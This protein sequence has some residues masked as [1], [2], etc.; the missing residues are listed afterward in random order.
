MHK[1][2][3][4]S[5]I[6]GASMLVSTAPALA[7]D[8]PAPAKEAEPPAA[9]APADAKD[10]FETM[11]GAIQNDKYGVFGSLASPTF[12][13]ALTP[14][15]FKSL[16]EQLAA[17]LQGGHEYRYLGA[18]N[19]AGF[20]VSLWRVRFK[21]GGDDFLCEISENAAGVSGFYLR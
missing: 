10:T 13:A 19:K 1:L 4:L 5:L 20:V 21:D 12:K 3:N 6:L 16:V 17:R 14:A 9:L 15:A 8:A 11:M 7:Q 2:W 18:L